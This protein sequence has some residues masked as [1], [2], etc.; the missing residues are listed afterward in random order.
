MH[1]SV[2]KSWGK[3]RVAR[4]DARNDKN[5]MQVFAIVRIGAFPVVVGILCRYDSAPIA[6]GHMPRWFVQISV[7]TVLGI[8]AITC[9][10]Y[11]QAQPGPVP[12]LRRWVDASS[13]IIKG[14]VLRTRETP[15]DS[16]GPPKSH[17][18]VATVG[19]ES[20][21]KG[22]LDA[23]EITIEYWELTE[24]PGNTVYQNFYSSHPG[25]IGILFLK[26]DRDERWIFA[27]SDRGLLHTVQNAPAAEM[28]ITT[29]SKLEAELI[30]TVPDDLYGHE[31]AWLLDSQLLDEKTAFQSG[32]FG[33]AG[34]LNPGVSDQ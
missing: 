19:I 34:L 8:L 21:L 5:H 22:R 1:R 18:S 25:D 32:L 28:A 33:Q 2:A 11:M 9:P 12:S 29:M 14:Q 17:R 7:S 13:L 27:S 20:F 30:A 3:F 24:A 31:A 26:R 10:R 16:E 4:L 15:G 6:E 23:I